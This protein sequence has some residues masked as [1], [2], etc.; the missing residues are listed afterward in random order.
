MRLLPKEY[1]LEDCELQ[2]KCWP[3]ECDSCLAVESSLGIVY[4]CSSSAHP[5]ITHLALSPGECRVVSE[6]LNSRL[7]EEQIKPLEVQKELFPQL[8]EQIDQTI[9][10]IKLFR[11]LK[12]CICNTDGCNDPEKRILES[13][14]GGDMN[15][16]TLS[17]LSNTTT[18][19]QVPREDDTTQADDNGIGYDGDENKVT[20]ATSS[21]MTTLLSGPQDDGNTPSESLGNGNGGNKSKGKFVSF[22]IASCIVMIV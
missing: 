11:V 9:E 16:V 15:K 1:E 19:P 8:E 13:S 4:E 20:F 18:L 5:V 3:H 10:E 22:L 2:K 17:T 14:F 6:E 7:Q 21:F 12:A